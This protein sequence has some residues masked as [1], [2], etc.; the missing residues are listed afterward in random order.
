VRVPGWMDRMSRVV[1]SNPMVFSLSP[2]SFI[3]L[4]AHHLTA[5]QRGADGSFIFEK[6][7]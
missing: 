5:L 3:F 2:I 1:W 7:G 6:E 4:S